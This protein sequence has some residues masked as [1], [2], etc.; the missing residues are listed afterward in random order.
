MNRLLLALFVSTVSLIAAAGDMLYLPSCRCDA[1][2]PYDQGPVMPQGKYKGLCQDTCY[3]RSIVLLPSDNPNLFKVANIRHAG[4]FY[5][6]EIPTDAI[7]QVL[8]HVVEAPNVFNFPA[9]HTEMRW[10]LKTPLTLTPQVP[11]KGTVTQVKDLI[12]SIEGAFPD[13]VEFNLLTSGMK[14]DYVIAYRIRTIDDLVPE[15]IQGSPFKDVEQHIVKLTDDQRKV[16]LKRALEYANASG[17]FQIYHS[18]HKN[19]S[20]EA[21][22]NVLDVAISR[23]KSNTKSMDMVYPVWNDRAL[24]ERKVWGGKA[25]NLSEELKNGPGAHVAP[26]AR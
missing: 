9:G 2:D 25:P 14:G 17:S 22:E 20:T 13:G 4:Y 15:T 6:A 11:G 8:W 26:A 3:Y 24:Q 18:L 23:P 10:K 7:D 5:T 19:C 1:R 12:F 16:M 21:F